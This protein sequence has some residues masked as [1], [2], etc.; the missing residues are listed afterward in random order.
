[1]MMLRRVVTVMMMMMMICV[2]LGITIGQLVVVWCARYVS[3]VLVMDQPVV[4][5][6][7]REENRESE[8]I[9]MVTVLLYLYCVLML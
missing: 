5:M 1:M 4:M 2:H 9:A 8:C 3:I 6:D 7:Y